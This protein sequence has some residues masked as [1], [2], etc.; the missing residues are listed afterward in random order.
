MFKQEKE[1]EVLLRQEEME[2]DGE[3]QV[4]DGIC[5]EVEGIYNEFEERQYIERLVAADEKNEYDGM[6]REDE[7]KIGGLKQLYLSYMQRMIGDKE[8]EKMIREN[9]MMFDMSI[10]VDDEEI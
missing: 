1:L 4:E 5:E 3:E 2:N 10:L 9:G 8:A 6:N 7:S